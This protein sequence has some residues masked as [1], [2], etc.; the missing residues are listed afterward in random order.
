MNIKEKILAEIEKNEKEVLGIFALR[1]EYLKIFRE[2]NSVYRNNETL[3]DYPDGLFEDFDYELYTFPYNSCNININ[4]LLSKVSSDVNIVFMFNGYLSKEHTRI[5]SEGLSVENIANKIK[6]GYYN[7]EKQFVEFYERNEDQILVLN[8]LL[9]RDGIYINV[10]PNVVLDKPIYLLNIIGELDRNYFINSRK[11]I[12]IEGNSSADLIEIDLVY[13]QFDTM[14]SEVFLLNVGENSNMNYSKMYFKPDSLKKVSNK[15]SSIKN[16]GY[17]IEKDANINVNNIFLDSIYNKNNTFV[18]FEGDNSTSNHSFFGL[19]TENKIIDLKSTIY[20]KAQNTQSNQLVKAIASDNSKI[21][22]D[23][24]IIIE[25]DANKTNATQNSKGILLSDNANIHFQPQL[26]IY[27]D[28]IKATH[29]SAVGNLDDELLFYLNQR[30]ITTDVA[31]KILLTAFA[32]DIINQSVA[33]EH[34][35]EYAIN[36]IMEKIV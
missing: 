35:K 14:Y 17:L 24:K 8:S 32:T 29:G 7:L 15:I 3:K 16:C 19:T 5:I 18:S 1:D 36:K 31:K 33:S 2:M 22:F 11:L 12:K 23:G 28:D 34:L 25:K 9:A 13:S 10:A 20:H 26:E 4:E 21:Y 27:N 30:G 6:T